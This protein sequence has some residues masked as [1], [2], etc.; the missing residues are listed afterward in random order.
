MRD[1]P[2]GFRLYLDILSNF[3]DYR[4]DGNAISFRCLFP[5]RHRNGDRN[6]SGRMWVGD[7]GELVAV[8]MGCKATWEEFVARTGTHP[9]DWWPNKRNKEPKGRRVMS[10]KVVA[11][12]EYRDKDGNLL[13]VK[14]RVE[15]GPNGAK[16]RFRWKRPLPDADRLRLGV[17]T[18]E[19]AWV[20][21]IQAGGFGRDPNGKGWH[22]GTGHAVEVEMPSCDPGLYRLR[23]LL[24]ADP[25]QPVCVVEGEK[26]ADNLSALGFVAT[27][28]PHGSNAWNHNYS[29]HFIGRRVVVFADN[30]PPGEGHANCIGGSMLAIRAASVRLVLPGPDWPIPAG[31]DVSQWLATLPEDRAAR[32][33]ALAT[34]CKKFPTYSTTTI[35]AA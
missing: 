18:G 12:Y 14:E 32:R 5:E 33:T 13:A 21:S 25:A 20:Y 28:P 24:A 31:G 29:T 9:A 4:P 10:G 7:R 34:L 3:D 30:D 11:A 23:D 8:C 1:S 19:A 6:W 16:K 26:D 35:K 22:F 15:P 17:P 2:A 27:S